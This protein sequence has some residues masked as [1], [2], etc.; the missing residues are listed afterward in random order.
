[1]AHSEI[2]NEFIAFFRVLE[3]FFINKIINI[4]IFM[5]IF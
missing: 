2:N 1:M 5:I 4:N 3:P